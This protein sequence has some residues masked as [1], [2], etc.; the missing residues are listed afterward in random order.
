MSPRLAWS[1]LY[2]KLTLNSFLILLPMPLECWDY[3]QAPGDP[4]CA[5]LGIEPMASYTLGKKHSAMR[6]TTP[7]KLY[8]LSEKIVCSV[9][10]TLT[11][12]SKTGRHPTFTSPSTKAIQR[13][14]GIRQL[15][16]SEGGRP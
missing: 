15:P 4:L 16:P 9:N 8:I 12:L 6:V 13:E 5:V 2:R 11:T 10:Y 14:H 3:R 1:S 7:T